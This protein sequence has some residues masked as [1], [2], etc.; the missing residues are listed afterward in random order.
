MNQTLSAKFKN[1]ASK[2]FLFENVQVDMKDASRYKI[3]Q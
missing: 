2:N 1:L 3:T